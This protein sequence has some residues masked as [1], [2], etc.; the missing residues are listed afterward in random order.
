MWSPSI[1]YTAR[2]ERKVGTY[3]THER[4]QRTTERVN[5]EIVATVV[6]SLREVGLEAQPGAVPLNQSARVVSGG[7]VRASRSRPRTASA[8]GRAGHVVAAVSVSLEAGGRCLLQIRTNG[9]QARAC[10]VPQGRRCPQC[11][12]RWD[13][14]IDG[15]PNERLSPDVEVP[16]RRLGHAVADRVLVYAKEQGWLAPPGQGVAE[17]SVPKSKRTI[18]PKARRGPAPGGPKV[19]GLLAAP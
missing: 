13:C 4:R 2:L 10:G 15:S 9:T 18:C 5:D 6:A 17:A 19:S 8:L 3:P 1:S 7:L 14:G 12:D 16:V 11:G